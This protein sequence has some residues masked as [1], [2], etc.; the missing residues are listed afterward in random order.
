MTSAGSSGGG[1]GLVSSEEELARLAPLP[2]ERVVYWGSGSPQGA[3]VLCP[4]SPKETSS[5]N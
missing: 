5:T 2:H 3:C 1:N 4:L